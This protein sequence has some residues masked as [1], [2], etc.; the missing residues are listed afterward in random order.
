[1]TR[2]SSTD[3]ASSFSDR[4]EPGAVR[5]DN[6]GVDLV[7]E[8]SGK[9]RTAELR[10]YFERGVRKVIVAAPIKKDALN[11]VIGVNDHLYDPAN[12]RHRHRRLVHDELSGAG[13]ESDA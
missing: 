5:W 11:V 10:P 1:M 7:L 6:S 12:P 8:C 4:G 3:G 13:G 9:F 2:S